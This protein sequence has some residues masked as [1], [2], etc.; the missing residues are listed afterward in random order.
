[1]K[2]LY[3]SLID[4]FLLNGIDVWH[5]TYVNITN[6]VFTFKKKACRVI[7]KLPSILTRKNTLKMKT[8]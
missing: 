3:Y 4:P 6:K 5:G 8:F 7:H 2:T 1:M